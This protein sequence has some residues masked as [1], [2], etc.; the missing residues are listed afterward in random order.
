M[1]N[2]LGVE[3][4]G[5]GVGLIREKYNESVKFWSENALVRWFLFLNYIDEKIYKY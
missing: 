2:A 4:G 1:R 5:S 3:H